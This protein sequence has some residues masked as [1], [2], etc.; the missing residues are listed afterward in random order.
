[1]TSWT[2]F[3]D[4]DYMQ[5]D[6]HLHSQREAIRQS[7]DAIANDIGMAM[8]DVGPDIPVFLTVPNSGNS[9]ATVATPIDPPDEDWCA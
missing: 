4:Q 1:M 7:L 5:F 8:R 9:L 2:T 3:D 6:D